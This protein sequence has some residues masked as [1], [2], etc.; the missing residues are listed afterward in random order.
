MSING[1]ICI[2]MQMYFVC[3]ILFYSR[4]TLTIPSHIT[5]TAEVRFYLLIPSDRKKSRKEEGASAHNNHH[6]RRTHSPAAGENICFAH[7]AV[8]ERS[9]DSHIAL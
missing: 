6:R 2:K 1:P 8:N 5:L 9:G 7:C 3:S 4:F